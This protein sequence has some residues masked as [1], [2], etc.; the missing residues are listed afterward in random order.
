[1]RLLGM[2]LALGA[3]GWV[4]YTASGGGKNDTIIPT[5]YQKSLEKAENV[6]ESVHEATELRSFKIEERKVD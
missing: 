2:A 3:I 4:S 1:M 6:E 5:G